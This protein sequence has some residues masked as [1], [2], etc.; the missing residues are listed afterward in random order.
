M[1]E[2]STFENKNF[3]FQKVYVVGEPGENAIIWSND[4]YGFNKGRTR[5]MCDLFA[6]EGYYVLLP[7]FYRDD[8]IHPYKEFEVSFPCYTLIIVYLN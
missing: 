4:V 7:N 2:F 1:R 5:Q 8:W 3:H 6:A